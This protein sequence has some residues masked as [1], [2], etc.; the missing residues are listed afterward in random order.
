MK[1][2]CSQLEFAGS[3]FTD[4]RS[5]GV[6]TKPDC[7]L[8]DERHGSRIFSHR[9]TNIKHDMTIRQ[10]RLHSKTDRNCQFRIVHEN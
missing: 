6:S 10:E 3:C 5:A 7:H 2:I 9:L 1:N 4:R 8:R